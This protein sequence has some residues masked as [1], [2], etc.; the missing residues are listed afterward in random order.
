MKAATKETPAT[1]QWTFNGKPLADGKQADGTTVAG[2]TTDTLKLSAVAA[3]SAGK[4]ALTASNKLDAWDV[5]GQ[6]LVQDKAPVS[7]TSSSA[8]LTVK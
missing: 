1:Y 3:S 8:M 6:A 7:A 5:A 2:A 4:Y